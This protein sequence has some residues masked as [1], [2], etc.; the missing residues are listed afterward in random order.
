MEVFPILSLFLCIQAEMRGQKI[1]KI[2]AAQREKM[3]HFRL[4]KG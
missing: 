4:D 1:Y 3:V 2:G